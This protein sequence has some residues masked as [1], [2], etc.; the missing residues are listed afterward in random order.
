MK[1][2]LDKNYTLRYRIGK[3]SRNGPNWFPQNRGLIKSKEISLTPVIVYDTMYIAHEGVFF[4]C[5]SA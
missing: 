2:F 1:V 4:K 5:K 3:K